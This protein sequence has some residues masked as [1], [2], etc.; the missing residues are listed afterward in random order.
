MLVLFFDTYY[1]P[2]ILAFAD[3]VIVSLSRDCKRESL[4][5]L[6][7]LAFADSVI[8]SFTRR[9]MKDSLLR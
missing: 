2:T 8:V 1:L 3:S 7:M 9:C 4:L 5:G 6:P